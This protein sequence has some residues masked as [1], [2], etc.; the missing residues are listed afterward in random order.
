[1]ASELPGALGDGSEVE[2]AVELA[3]PNLRQRIDPLIEE[4]P[5]LRERV[6]PEGRG[7]WVT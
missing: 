2:A 5:E 4:S 1:M 3:K 6:K 7:T